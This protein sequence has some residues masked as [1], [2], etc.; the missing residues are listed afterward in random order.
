MAGAAKG[1]HQRHHRRGGWRVRGCARGAKNGGKC[2]EMFFARRARARAR[3]FFH[4]TPVNA[5][6][7]ASS[8]GATPGAKLGSVTRTPGAPFV[9]RGAHCTAP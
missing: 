7:H 4:A 6:V 3:P 2:F 8:Q 1:G 5:T 9:V